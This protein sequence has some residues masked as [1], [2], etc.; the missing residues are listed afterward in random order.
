MKFSVQTC[1]LVL[2]ALCA[3]TAEYKKHGY[4]IAKMALNE[5]PRILEIL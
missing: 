1:T 3:C 4:Y 2:L 5:L